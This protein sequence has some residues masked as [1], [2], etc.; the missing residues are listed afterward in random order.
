MFVRAVR[1][2]S[3]TNQYLEDNGDGT[4]TDW[5]TSLM[6]EQH[7]ENTYIPRGYWELGLNYCEELNLA[8]MDDWRL[9]NVNELTSLV[10]FNRNDPSIDT[11]YFPATVSDYYWS[12]TGIPNRVATDSAA[13]VSFRSGSTT[14]AKVEDG[15]NSQKYW[16]CV[17]SIKYTTYPTQ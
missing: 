3:I 7:D 6:W 12:S 8:G 5:G 17:R 2:E 16:R 15:A 1:G 4:V 13:I 9:P 11:A 10:D 14:K